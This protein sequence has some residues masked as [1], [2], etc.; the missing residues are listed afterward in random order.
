MF[1]EVP[2][3]RLHVQVEGQGLPCL[4]PA[5]D[6]G[7]YQRTLSARLREHLQL[8]FVEL[9]GSGESDPCPLE[10]VTLAT[11]VDDLDRV[12]Q[13]L[14]LE[15]VAVMGTSM[16]G[17]FPLL[18]ALS[19]PAH[20]SHLVVGCTVPGMLLDWQQQRGAYWETH[21]SAE[22]KALRQEVESHI[23][24]ETAGLPPAAAF[25][26]SYIRTSYLFW[27]APHFDSTPY[28]AGTRNF[29]PA[30]HNLIRR[31]W[32]ATDTVGQLGEIAAP[33]LLFMGAHDYVFPPTV[34]D[35]VRERLQD[36]TYRLFEQAG[37]NPQ[38]EDQEAFDRELLAWL[39]SHGA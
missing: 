10:D 35:G 36:C 28:H 39:R 14:G 33:V 7:F 12:R 15:R 3:T 6:A 29:N 2:G 1:V 17:V 4:V 38:V 27:A 21:A 13:A 26:H 18:Y 24:E 5:N 30:L 31:D 34:W 9:R 20:A 32:A 19:S 11:L 37:H 16:Y 25:I 23:A 22:R 8:V